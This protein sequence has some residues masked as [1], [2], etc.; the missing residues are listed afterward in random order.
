MPFWSDY[1]A[2]SSQ[3][4]QEEIEHANE[5][6][7]E[8]AKISKIGMKAVWKYDDNMYEYVG[9]EYLPVPFY[10]KEE[11]VKIFDGLPGMS[12]SDRYQTLI[13]ED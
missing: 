11:L 1:Q 10:E 7:K 4:Q 12:N 5:E 13:D 9:I 3:Q 2:I 8:M 6:Q